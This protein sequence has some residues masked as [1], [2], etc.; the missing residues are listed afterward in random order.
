MVSKGLSC[1]KVWG[2]SISAFCTAIRSIYRKS[3]LNMHKVKLSITWVIFPTFQNWA[4]CEKKYYND[5]KD[6]TL[7]LPICLFLKAHNFLRTS[8]LG[9]YP[10]ILIPAPNGDHCLYIQQ[11]QRLENVKYNS[12]FF[13]YEKRNPHRV[14]GSSLKRNET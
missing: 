9:K 4:F 2:N 14:E 5:N 1:E 7:C 11:P 13:K 12:Q 3:L 8:A 6:S 10:T